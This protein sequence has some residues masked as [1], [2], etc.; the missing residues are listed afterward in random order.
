MNNDIYSEQRLDGA[1]LIAEKATQ[2]AHS[3]GIIL[4]R[5]E[6][7]N[8]LPIV[9]RTNHILS[10]TYKGKTITGKFPDE[11]LADYPARVG[12]EKAKALIKEMVRQLS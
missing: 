2:L 9:D 12:I 4:E 10:L 1:R 3:K 6:W 11:W 8:D 7:D 5:I